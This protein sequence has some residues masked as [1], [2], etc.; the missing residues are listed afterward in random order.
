MKYSEL[1]QYEPIRRVV[2]L[3]SKVT[4]APDANADPAEA[5]KKIQARVVVHTRDGR[6][7]DQ[8]VDNAL[9]KVST[10]A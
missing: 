8:F 1:I 2:A 6:R 7:L 3:R 9:G 5:M 10:A 4:V